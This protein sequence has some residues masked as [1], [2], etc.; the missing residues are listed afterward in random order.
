[1]REEIHEI[2]VVSEF[3]VVNHA[4]NFH[5]KSDSKRLVG[6][7]Q[8]PNQKSWPFC[9]VIIALSKETIE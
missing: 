4:E 8:S 5:G 3:D 1:M 2:F 9:F 7:Q 6:R